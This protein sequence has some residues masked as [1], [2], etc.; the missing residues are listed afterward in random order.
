M[1][2]RV[3]FSSGRHSQDFAALDTDTTHKLVASTDFEQ[4][5]LPIDFL[6][7]FF[8]GRKLKP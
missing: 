5:S 8:S 4:C 2:L 7:L 3:L 1:Y 6:F